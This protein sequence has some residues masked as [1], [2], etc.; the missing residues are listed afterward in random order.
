MIFDGACRRLGYC[1]TG[2]SNMRATKGAVRQK[3]IAAHN[4][5]GEIQF[6][7]YTDQ[8][9]KLQAM[10]TLKS[11]KNVEIG[12]GQITGLILAFFT[13]NT[14]SLTDLGQEYKWCPAGNIMGSTW[15]GITCITKAVSWWQVSRTTQLL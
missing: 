13:G 4:L 3:I 6:V 15:C 10:L 5:E 8:H 12:L 14:S 11:R 2:N 1:D 7:G 9:N